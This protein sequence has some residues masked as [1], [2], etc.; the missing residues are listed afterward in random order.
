MELGKDI[1]TIDQDDI[2]CAFQLKTGNVTLHQWRENIAAQ[3]SDL[4]T[5]QISHPSVDNSIHHR[6]YLVTNGRIDEEVSR[7]IEDRNQAW[8]RQG[9][10][11]SLETYVRGQLFEKAKRLGT[12][13]WPSEL[14]DI[15]TLLEMYLENGAGIL[16]KENYRRCL[17]LPFNLIM[18]PHLLTTNV[19]EI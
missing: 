8:A 17:N 3:T 7:A 2:P 5:L 10:S 6:S 11:Y 12:D 19:N 18:N 13:L 15:R 4:V 14:T 16:T 9:L 1:I